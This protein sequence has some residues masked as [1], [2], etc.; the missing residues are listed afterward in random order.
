MTFNSWTFLF[1]IVNFLVLIYILQR[2]LYR[3]LHDA[4]D[5]R[6]Q[7]IERMQ[8]DAENE[9]QQAADQHRKLEEQLAAIAEERQRT[10]EDTKH[11]AEAERQQILIQAAHETERRA[12]LAQESLERERREMMQALEQTVVQDASR[13]AE[14]LLRDASDEDLDTRLAN[15]LAQTVGSLAPAEREGL[16]RNWNA[17][18]TATLEAAHDLPP[19]TVKQV[20]DAVAGVLGHDIAL[21]VQLTPEL[22]CGVRLRLDGHIW[23]ASLASQMKGNDND[24][25][26]VGTR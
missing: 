13:L 11:E 9:R 20:H 12:A 5:R 21:H 24:R 25:T 22:V 7:A 3:P 1:E 6:R 16:I 15:R 10:L 17:G 18:E 4:V 8:A 14:R 23:D 19:E 26:P 2:L